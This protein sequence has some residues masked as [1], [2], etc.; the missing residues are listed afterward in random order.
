MSD[1]FSSKEYKVLEA[2][3]DIGKNVGF[4]FSFEFCKFCWEFFIFLFDFSFKY[5]DGSVETMKQ[6]L[7]KL[8][9]LIGMKNDFGTSFIEEDR[10]SRNVSFIFQWNFDLENFFQR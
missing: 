6:P 3:S 4:V 10:A 7:A 8:R 1:S 9:P 2:R 5:F